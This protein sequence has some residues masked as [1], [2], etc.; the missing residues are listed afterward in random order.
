MIFRPCASGLWRKS[1]C[2]DAV[3]RDTGFEEIGF[4]SLSSSDHS[5]IDELVGQV[6]ARYGNEK[7][8]IGLPSLRIESF[9]VELMEKLEKGRRRSGF[10]FAPRPPPIG[11]GT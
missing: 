10:T 7:L 8:S 3:V 9:S 1:C 11:C 6:V 5:R 2:V 4:L